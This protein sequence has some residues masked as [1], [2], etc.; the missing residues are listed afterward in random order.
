MSYNKQSQQTKPVKASQLLSNLSQM[1]EMMKEILDRQKG[2]NSTGTQE[3]YSSST[4]V[5]SSMSSS[6]FSS[7]SEDHSSS[8]PILTITQLRT[9]VPSALYDT[10]CVSNDLTPVRYYCLSVNFS[11]SIFCIIYF[12]SSLAN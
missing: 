9:L 12:R 1:S 6:S 4:S 10:L 8:V 7:S 3:Q 11:I 5:S 2:F